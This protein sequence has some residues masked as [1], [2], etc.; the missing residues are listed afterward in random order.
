[1]KKG[2]SAFEELM[3]DIFR[4]YDI[5]KK[6]FNTERIAEDCKDPE[7]AQRMKVLIENYYKEECAWLKKSEDK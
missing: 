2:Q 4:Y 3:R 5:D 7:R 1:M 6:E